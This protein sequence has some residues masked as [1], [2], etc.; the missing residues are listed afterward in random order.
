MRQLMLSLVVLMAVTG[1][2]G[3]KSS[4]LLE[5][6][7]RGPLDEALLVAHRMEWHLEPM[8]QAQTKQGV[9]VVVNHA[10]REWLGHFFENKKLFGTYTGRNPYYLENLVFY[11]QVT[12]RSDER[13][14]VDPGAFVTVDDRGNQFAVVGMDY[15]S[16]LAE[17]RA[18]I[19]TMTRGVLEDA[20]PGYFG[21]S[22]PL[23]KMVSAKPQ[24]Q[25]ALIKQSAL[26]AGYYYPGVSHD[27]LITFWN[28]STN[29]TKVK[30][31]I[32]DIRT[33]IS[34]ENLAKSALSF[35]FEF[36]ATKP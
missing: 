13:I 2:G 33:D 25:F 23:G 1:C 19:A 9:E 18:P 5:R 15:L 34:P 24:G 28:P 36:A 8:R 10:S 4:L 12:N 21:L 11:I 26:Q 32:P 7:A 22:L 17:A 6:N 27:G 16:A 30:L 31:F 14:F 35:V 29:A 3:R 20:R